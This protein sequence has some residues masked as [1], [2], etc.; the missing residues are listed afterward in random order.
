M[1]EY[2]DHEL[3]RECC[4]DSHVWAKTVRARTPDRAIDAMRRRIEREGNDPQDCVVYQGRLPTP[5]VVRRGLAAAGDGPYPPILSAYL[6]RRPL[7]VDRLRA[8]DSDASPVPFG[9]MPRHGV[10][11]G[12]GKAA[13]CDCYEPWWPV[14]ENTSIRLD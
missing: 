9:L 3:H 14:D 6:S 5:L 12:C 2:R 11:V 10:L 1:H 7:L 8:L 4:A 13:C